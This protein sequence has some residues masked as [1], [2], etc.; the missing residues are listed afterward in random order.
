MERDEFEVIGHHRC[1][2]CGNLIPTVGGSHRQKLCGSCCGDV[3]EAV[4]AAAFA[5]EVEG[6]VYEVKAG[7]ASRRQRP[8][9]PARP[10]T[11]T[12]RDLD[13]RRGRARG[14]ALTRLA[15]IYR[16]MF[17]VLLNEEKLRLGLD[18]VTSAQEP[19]AYATTDELAADIF[20]SIERDAV[21][22]ARRNAGR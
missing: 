6:R 2:R 20:D 13:R 19:R 10:R 21:L 16:P 3:G 15:A 22:S 12:G 8:G 7:K 14:R 5:Y 4:D 9:A 11:E 1:E 17:E 18:P